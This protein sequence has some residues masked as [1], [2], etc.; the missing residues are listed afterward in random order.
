M[1][2]LSSEDAR[3]KFV[4]IIELDKALGKMTLDSY[5]RE[6]KDTAEVRKALNTDDA[7]ALLIDEFRAGTILVLGG[8]PENLPELIPIL[9]IAIRQA[10]LGNFSPAAIIANTGNERANRD[11]LNAGCTISAEKKKDIPLVI[12][13][14]GASRVARDLRAL[15]L[16]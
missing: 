11:L 7:Y 2:T 3:K 14:Y 4:L 13:N 1:G 6:L 8:A 5:T 16:R 10:K 12:K 9:E 15:E